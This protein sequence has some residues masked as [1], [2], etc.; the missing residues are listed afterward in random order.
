MIFDDPTH[1]TGEWLRGE[2]K[3]ADVVISSRVRL[4]RNLSDF[5]FLNSASPGQ[6]SEI[7]RAVA[8]QVMACGE[9]EQAELIDLRDADELDRQILVERH[10]ISQ[11]HAEAEGSRGVTVW[12]DETL[13]IMINEEDHLR[14][15]G[16]RSG[17]DL[18]ALWAR[19]GAVDDRIGRRL[20][21]AYDKKLGFLTACPTNVGTGIR[22]SVML[23]LPALKLSQEIERVSR[24][25]RDLRLAVRGLHG[26]G[27]EAVG[28]LVQ[29]SNQTTLGQSE[30]EIITSIGQ[31]VIPQIV[32]YERLARQELVKQHPEQIDDRIWRA[33]GTL[34]NARCI[35]TEE[36]L[37]MLSHLRMGI[38][39]GRFDRID[40]PT[41]N[42]LFLLTQPAHLQKLIGRTLEGRERAVA[43]AD[44][45]RNRLAS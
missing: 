44:F 16:L 30:D 19:L 22:V 5:P 39:M 45:L 42:E 1:S 41:L 29:I 2:G 32:E 4:A 18:D 10:L 27:T 40:I 14:I 15:Q 34:S 36:T 9:E 8:D 23:H 33:F 6:R 21:Y 24:A 28:D 7:F 11:Q 31:A 3:Y 20:E 37:G 13:A 38:H 35:G 25:T 17:L 43:R 12:P 26:E